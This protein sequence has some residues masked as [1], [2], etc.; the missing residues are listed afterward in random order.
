MIKKRC[1]SSLM[2][3]APFHITKFGNLTLCNATVHFFFFF[4]KQKPK[5]NQRHCTR[6][7]KVLY[8]IEFKIL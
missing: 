4:E 3:N 8:Y 6:V 2:P 7:S 1:G 5:N